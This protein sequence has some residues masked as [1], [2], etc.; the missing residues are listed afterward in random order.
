MGIQV[1]VQVTRLGVPFP[2]LPLCVNP[3]PDVLA[4][5]ATGSCP[6][7]ELQGKK[8]GVLPFRRPD[9]LPPGLQVQ[10]R[11][12]F[13]NVGRLGLSNEAIRGASVP[14][15]H[16][17]IIERADKP[18]MLSLTGSEVLE[19]ILYRR[20]RLLPGGPEIELFS[21]HFHEI[22]HHNGLDQVLLPCAH[23]LIRAS[24]DSQA[25]FLKKASM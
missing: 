2:P 16:Q 12:H 18:H 10:D 20:I 5:S 14:V 19:K 13:P 7:L 25:M 3:F 4:S 6:G 1:R 15:V 9:L 17:R 21:P 11:N 23:Y 8:K 22:S 24:A